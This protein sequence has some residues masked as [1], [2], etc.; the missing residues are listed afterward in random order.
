M[1]GKIPN[2]IS[3]A[4]TLSICAESITT[5]GILAHT[6][7]RS[8]ARVTKNPIKRTSVNVTETAE[9]IKG[10]NISEGTPAQMMKATTPANA[11]KKTIAIHLMA[12]L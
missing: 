3:A 1:A 12:R 10:T 2:E 9:G 8:L 5:V 11:R 4:R 7:L 6:R